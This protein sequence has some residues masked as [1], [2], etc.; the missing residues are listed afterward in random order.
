MNVLILNSLDERY[1]STYRLRAF[2]R[3]LA[4]LGPA[5]YV[6][7]NHGPWAKLLRL[8][9]A[10]L[11]HAYDVLFTQ[12]FN[13]ITLA[14]VLI[15]RVR[16]KRVVVDWDDFDVGYQSTLV[17][18][19][20][21]ALCERLG[22]SLCH[23]LVTHNERI[24]AR[25]RAFAPVTLVEQGFDETSFDPRSYVKTT[26]KSAWNLP[27]DHR[28]VGHLCT[29]TH[30]GTVDLDVILRAWSEITCPSVTFFLIGGGPLEAE[31]RRKIHRFGVESRVVMTGLLPHEKIPAALSALDVGVVYMS[32]SPSNEAR[33]SFKVIEYLAMNVPVVGRVVGETRKR[34]GDHVH[35]ATPESLA[36]KIEEIAFKKSHP[37]TRETVMPH[38][39]SRTTHPLLDLFTS[40]ENACR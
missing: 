26:A 4:S 40:M 29:F 31:I 11:F 22:P 7:T 28:V 23:H 18:K 6:E 24:L 36:A 37:P 33:V 38:A 14:C 12:K 3:A 13:P 1:G 25:A 39:W 21:A 30:G 34:F 5:M 27:P 10:S 9:Q 19:F 35:E 16:G 17:K 2:H 15:A 20:I 8:T 32:A